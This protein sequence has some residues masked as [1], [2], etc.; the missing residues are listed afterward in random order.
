VILEGGRVQAV[1]CLGRGSCVDLLHDYLQSGLIEIHISLPMLLSIIEIC[2]YGYL[3]GGIFGHA[4]L[5]RA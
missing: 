4:L 5:L 3:L 2:H 1:D